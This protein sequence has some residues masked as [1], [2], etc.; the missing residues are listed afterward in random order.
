[1]ST[2]EFSVDADSDKARRMAMTAWVE[3]RSGDHLMFDGNVVEAFCADEKLQVRCATAPQFNSDLV[4]CAARTP[5]FQAVRVLVLD[6]GLRL[7]EADDEN[8]ICKTRSRSFDWDCL[9]DEVE[10][11]ANCDQALELLKH[12]PEGNISEPEKELIHQGLAFIRR[13]A[14]ETRYADEPMDKI[15]ASAY[16]RGVR[17]WRAEAWRYRRGVDEHEVIVPIGNIVVPM[18]AVDVAG[19]TFMD[20]SRTSVMKQYLT[21]DMGPFLRDGWELPVL[22]R[23][24]VTGSDLWSA[25]QAGREKVA[26][27]VEAVVFRLN[28]SPSMWK[29]ADSRYESTR[30]AR[31]SGSCPR[32]SDNSLVHNLATDEYWL[33]PIGRAR[34]PDL[35]ELRARGGRLLDALSISPLDWPDT[36]LAAHIRAALHWSYRAAASESLVDRFLLRWIALEMLLC[37]EDDGTP[38]MIR[39]M[40]FAVVSVEGKVKPMRRELEKSWILLRNE[41][42]HRALHAHPRLSEGTRR[43]HYF[44]DATIAHAI[45]RLDEDQTFGSWLAYLD[46]QAL[47]KPPDT[48]ATS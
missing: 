21:D 29:T 22:A 33:G 18:S 10:S 27:G 13:A 39:R 28:Y 4:A 17:E 34:E 36:D 3:I 24:V 7:P 26:Q 2:A 37:G 15:P 42:V 32:M 43:I 48:R 9:L 46:A 31:P 14:K 1:M 5:W 12:L 35:V 38:A 20:A 23:T 25:R 8:L 11:A 47:S 45:A 40:P 30:F 6:E 16:R 19:V 41:V 44:S